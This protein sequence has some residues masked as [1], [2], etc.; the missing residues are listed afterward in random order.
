MFWR[1]EVRLVLAGKSRQ[2][3]VSSG[4]QR[5]VGVWHGRHGKVK[6]GV[7]WRVMVSCGAAGRGEAGLERKE[8]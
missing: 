6:C 5:L 3:A 4:E 2:V 7:V 1:A 8:R